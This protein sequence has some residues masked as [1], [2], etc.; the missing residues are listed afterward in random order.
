MGLIRWLHEAG[1]PSDIL[2]VRKGKARYVIPNYP[3]P[4][5]VLPEAKM[6][7]K[8]LINEFGAKSVEPK[9]GTVRKLLA[10]PDSFDLLHFAC[11]GV[12]EHDNIS[13]AQLLMQGRIEGKNYIPDR[14][15]ATTVDAHAKLRSDGRAPMIVL[16]ACQAGR[17]GYKLTGLGGFAQAFL[18]RGAGVFVGTLWSV[19]DSPARHFTEEFYAQLKKG[20]TIA[21]AAI[22][23]RET[24][25]KA[26]DA[27]WLSYVVY[28]HP[29]AKLST[30]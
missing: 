6:E 30:V 20:G 29:H 21:E 16:N 19:G 5:Y 28:A 22:A 7:S 10:E 13:N 26:G 2:T 23:A 25:R 4:D 15:N 24:A 12:A 11:H 27:T 9:S 18:R 14:L 8:F 3:H 1:W 17:A